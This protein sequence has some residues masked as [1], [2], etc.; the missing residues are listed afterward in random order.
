MKNKTMIPFLATIIISAMLI[1]TFFLPL[2]V[3]TDEYREMISSFSTKTAIAECDY[4][5][6]DLENLSMFKY[7]NIYKVGASSKEVDGY[8]NAESTICFVLIIAV[9]IFT[10]LIL[11]FS[12]LKKPVPLVIFDI[13]A[14]GVFSL[15]LWDMGDRNVLPSTRYDFG[16]AHVLYYVCFAILAATGI[17]LFAVKKQKK[18]EKMEEMM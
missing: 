6:G 2:A 4:S 8:G 14:L 13:L 1:V 10:L 9:A 3:A 11:L 18:K 12:V 16:I 17:W 7:A 15:L 5:Y